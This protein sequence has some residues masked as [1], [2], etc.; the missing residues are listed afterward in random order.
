MFSNVLHV[1]RQSLQSFRQTLER[2]WNT[3]QLIASIIDRLNAT[4]KLSAQTQQLLKSLERSRDGTGIYLSL[5]HLN[6]LMVALDLR[7]N[8]SVGADSLCVDNRELVSGV[9]SSAQRFAPY[10]HM[11]SRVKAYYSSAVLSVAVRELLRHSA[12]DVASLQMMSRCI[13]SA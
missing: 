13:T 1:C 7:A 6:K 9:M 8:K 2:L 10:M 12:A 3:H 5:C 4:Q 11:G